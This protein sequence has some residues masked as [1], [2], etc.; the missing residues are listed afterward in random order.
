MKN[1]R[2]A[3]GVRVVDGK[4]GNYSALIVQEGHS[5]GQGHGSQ[6]GTRFA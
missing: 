3:E 5:C 2:E 4:A 6:R 1:Q